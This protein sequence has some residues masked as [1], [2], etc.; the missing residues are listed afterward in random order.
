MDFGGDKFLGTDMSQ[1]QFG[2]MAEAEGQDDLVDTRDAKINAICNELDDLD[3]MD[4]SDYIDGLIEG[5]DIDID[6]LTISE[7]RRI[8]RHM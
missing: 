2:Y 4:K 7:R 1:G 8:D 6:S 3:G 5:K